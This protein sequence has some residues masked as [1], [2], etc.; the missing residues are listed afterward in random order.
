MA[1]GNLLEELTL[2]IIVEPTLSE[3]F[4][5][6]LGDLGA[7]GFWSVQHES[8]DIALNLSREDFGKTS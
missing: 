7:V 4:L 3:F 8:T 5:S 2:E 6:S 1:V